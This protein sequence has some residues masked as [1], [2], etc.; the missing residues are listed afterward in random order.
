M[1]E[2]AARLSCVDNRTGYL[3]TDI[4]YYYSKLPVSSFFSPSKVLSLDAFRFIFSDPDF[5]KALKSGFIL[6]TGLVVIAIPLGGSWP[7]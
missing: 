6:A 3:H 2:L 4:I 7:F 5:Y 1:A